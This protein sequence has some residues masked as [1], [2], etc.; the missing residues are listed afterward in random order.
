MGDGDFVKGGTVKLS[1]MNIGNLD[2]GNL[3][4][5]FLNTGS[6][7]VLE[8]GVSIDSSALITNC[9]SSIAHDWV[10]EP[11]GLLDLKGFNA[12]M[13]SIA[14]IG[15]GVLTNTATGVSTLTLGEGDADTTY[16]KSIPPRIDIVKVG[17]GTLSMYATD[18]DKVHVLAGELALKSRKEIGY[19]FYKFNVY[20]PR[21]EPV[22]NATV[23]MAEIKYLDGDKDVTLGMDAYYYDPSGTSNY[24]T[25][26]NAWDRDLS[27]YFKDGRASDYAKITN[28]HFEVEYRPSRKITGYTWAT[29]DQSYHTDLRD[30]GVFGS[31][32]NAT[33]ERLDLVEEFQ[34]TQDRMTWVG[35][36]FVFRFAN[37]MVAVGNADVADG[38]RLT[39]SGASVALSSLALGSDASV[40]VRSGATLEFPAAVSVSKLEVNADDEVSTLI[41]FTRASAGT[42]YL[43]GTTD[44]PSRDLPVLV[45]GA[46]EVWAGWTVVYNGVE[47]PY[48]PL[49]K[50]GM[51]HLRGTRGLIIV[52]E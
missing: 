46:D 39:V 4:M 7:R 9:V 41:G 26:D 49:V 27:T 19:P 36:N 25:P 51:L 6:I 28:I 14:V 45:G 30:W 12:I 29:S 33:W 52:V 18:V 15:T 43:T 5:R 22:K 31:L 48:M 38:A 10:V 50:D 35:T 1:L 42:L 23:T 32:D 47:V 20:K 13:R 11:E 8:G 2:T 24:F 21:R 44:R 34:A 16:Q 3:N 37:Q 40:A 17:Q